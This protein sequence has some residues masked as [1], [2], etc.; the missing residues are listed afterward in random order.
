VEHTLATPPVH[1]VDRPYPVTATA[2]FNVQDVHEDGAAVNPAA[3]YPHHSALLGNLNV[4]AGVGVGAINPYPFAL[5]GVI[6]G[7]IC[8]SHNNEFA[9][10]VCPPRNW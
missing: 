1:V 2:V 7:D 4:V 9:E 10:H 8:E 3:E 5:T 6:V